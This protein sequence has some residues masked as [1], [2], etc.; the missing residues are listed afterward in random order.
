MN[1][2]NP[3]NAKAV[4]SISINKGFTLI[5]L[6]I[7]VTI[8]SLILLFIATVF[9]QINRAYTQG[10]ITKQTQES[11]REVLETVKRDFRTASSSGQLRIECADQ[12]ECD[13]PEEPTHRLCFD[14]KA[15]NFTPPDSSAEIEGQFRFDA[16]AN[17]AEEDPD[18]TAGSSLFG[19]NVQPQ[20]FKVSELVPDRTYKLELMVSTAS[21]S[22]DLLA[23]VDEEAG[24][25]VR[26]LACTPG[27]IG[28][29]FC[30]VV[31]LETL[32]TLRIE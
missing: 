32:V 10:L 11:G 7:A 29:Q 22:D 27:V 23:E 6:L 19:D 5:E 4:A 21:Y 18:L 1:S 3:S 28:S 25:G 26:D 12:D 20:F 8:F 30:N 9:I 31:Y 17:C 24:E 14:G 15:Y 2:S 13:S 16:S